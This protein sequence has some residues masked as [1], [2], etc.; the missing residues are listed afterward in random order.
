MVTP[1]KE[2]AS[3][4]VRQHLPHP[5]APE[6]QEHLGSF[7]ASLCKQPPACDSTAIKTQSHSRKTL[8]EM[9]E[10]HA[11]AWARRRERAPLLGL[12]ISSVDRNTPQTTR[13]S[14]SGPSEVAH[15]ILATWTSVLEIRECTPTCPL[16]SWWLCVSSSLM[17][18]PRGAGLAALWLRFLLDHLSAL[19]VG[20][21]D[22]NSGSS[23]LPM[24]KGGTA[25]H[26]SKAALCS[27]W[28]CPY[29]ACSE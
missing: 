15:R 16:L 25:R 9:A 26:S 8:R 19:R 11:Q 1:G 18:G 2:G 29:P 5:F 20:V 12:M 13:P 28:T 24:C 10:V 3:C 23:H 4:S 6:K 7:R 22:V 27:V 21:N 14:G 17:E